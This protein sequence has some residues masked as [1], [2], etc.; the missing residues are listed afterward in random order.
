M[1]LSACLSSPVVVFLGKNVEGTLC[2]QVIN[3]TLWH[4]P[5]PVRYTEAKR[6]SVAL[7]SR[8]S[9]GGTCVPAALC[10]VFPTSPFEA[11]S[12]FFNF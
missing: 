6:E 7:G 5:Q 11:V 9:E 2:K 12:P 1:G 8:V 4:S 3:H 10:Q